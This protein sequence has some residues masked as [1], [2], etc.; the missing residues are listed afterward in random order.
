MKTKAEMRLLFLEAAAELAAIVGL[1]AWIRYLWLYGT[2][3]R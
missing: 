3:W 2:P 1:C